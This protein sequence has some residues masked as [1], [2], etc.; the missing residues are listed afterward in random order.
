MPP[1]TASST[2]LP[3]ETAAQLT[4]FARACKGAARAVSLYPAEHPAIETALSR[5]A[6]AAAS[7]AARQPFTMAVL[8][9]NLLVDGRGCARPDAA[10]ADL[11]ALLHSHLIGQLRVL[12]R[13]DAGS[14]RIFLNLLAQDPLKIR[15]QGGIARAWAT[16]GGLGIEVQELDYS[17]IIEE[18]GSGEEA[19]W[20]A[21]IANC[22]SV[23]ALDLNDETL[24]ALAAIAADAKRLGDLMARLEEQA[25]GTG[26]SHGRAASIV[27]LL[28]A[29]H[30]HVAREDP[31]SLETVLRNL[32]AAVTRFSP[33]LLLDLLGAS[34][35]PNEEAAPLAE[36]FARVTDPMIAR[37][38]ARVVVAERGCTARLAEAFRALAP[39]PQRQRTVA[40]LARREAANS[41]LG[42][43]AGF[44]QLWARV[45]ELLVSYSDKP[46]VPESYNL[47]LSA[48]RARSLEIEHVP[49]DPPARIAAWLTTVSDAHL[50]AL[51]L[52]LLLDLLRIER[53][54]ERWPDVL[55][56]VTTQVDDLL[57]VGDLAGGRRL[58]EALVAAAR[59]QSDPR[60]AA[61]AQAID[62]LV[63]GPMISVLAGHLNTVD[64]EGVEQVKGL[65]A[66]IGSALIPR[67]ADALSAEGRAR[68]RQRLTE[69][70]MM[71]GEE[72][73][74]S[75]DKLRRSPS[76]SVRRTAVQIMRTFGG[77]EAVHDLAQMLEDPETSVQREAVRALISL[78]SADGHALLQE[79]LASDTSPARAAV[80]QELT[81]TRDENATP[82][83]CYIV[84][85]GVCR[86]SLREIYLKA[87]ARLGAVGGREAIETLREVLNRG[88][89]WAPRRTREVRTA[90]AA[91]LAAMKD[92]AGRPV[93]EEAAA[94]GAFGVRRV[95]R[96]FL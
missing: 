64:E 9:D 21:I 82:L 65:C 63:R 80:F 11:A 66:A 28:V 16:A 36:V 6:A 8:P 3:P 95:A 47:E 68:S 73:R 33:E 5:L 40:G 22:L 83:F 34:R 81:T 20:N 44:E 74:Q 79:T 96:K 4:T 57:L 24:G 49:D 18:R 15:S 90:A 62:Q 23:D 52:Q 71:F 59:D 45:E 85:N 54:L 86:G 67:L 77:D 70:L 29:L 53:D 46:F 35:Q 19:T 78:G 1:E 32:A 92:G 42:A 48:A 30:R 13:A 93:L 51:D 38:V 76:P 14:W 27:R 31:A 37:F 87:V 84:R 10:I 55:E 41:S 89:I 88:N 69:L 56:L 91:A 94:Q 50:R 7:A 12:R 17:T 75:V 25:S 26:E 72:G 61:A 60:T 58:V 39:D 43:E 2:V